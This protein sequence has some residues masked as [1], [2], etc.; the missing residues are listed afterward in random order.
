MPNLSLRVPSESI[1]LWKRLF[2]VRSDRIK[3]DRK[4]PILEPFDRT[5]RGP[6]YLDLN[7][8]S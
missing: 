8:E 1:G 2:V 3:K 7:I 5:R 6:F 4:V